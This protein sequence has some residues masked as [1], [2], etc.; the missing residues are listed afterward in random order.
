MLE[1]TVVMS[2]YNGGPYL[3]PAIESILTQSIRDFKFL[4]VDDGSTDGSTRILEEYARRDSRIRLIRQA[5]AGTIASLIK[6]CG[7]VATPYIAR[8]DADDISAPDRFEGQL[9]F[10]GRNREVALL[11]SAAEYINDAGEVLFTAEFPTSDDDIRARLATHN[12]FVSSAVV[13]RRDAALMVGG[14]RRA[15]LYAEDYDLW[16]RI[17]ER[18][19]AANLTNA[20]VSYRVHANQATTKGLEQQLLSAI[21]A[22]VSAKMRQTPGGDPFD[23]STLPVSREQLCRLGVAGSEIEEQLGKGYAAWA[24]VMMQSGYYEGAATLANEARRR[25]GS[26]VLTRERLARFYFAYARARALEGRVVQGA[27]Q[28][29]RAVW[30]HPTLLLRL[31]SRSREG[32]GG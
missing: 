24:E 14:Y 31:F 20:L 30:L 25:G 16:L 22:R 17:A 3:R 13:M 21:G 28:A 11:G 12:V 7:L 8:M 18:Y 6:A 15:F 23:Q 27:I 4:I 9:D 26:G 19:K 32:D 29:T 1:L 10:L 5:N 2:V